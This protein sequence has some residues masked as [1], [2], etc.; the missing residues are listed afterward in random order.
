MTRPFIPDFKPQ[1]E[2]LRRVLG[3]LEADVMETMWQMGECSVRDV[4]ERMRLD[5]EL[6]YTTVMTVM[7]R[8]SDKGLLSRRQRGKAYIYVPSMGRE[9]YL[10][11]V[12]GEVMD[13]LLFSHRD[14]VISHFVD[15]LGEADEK[16]LSELE[17]IIRQKRRQ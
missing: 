9:Q 14:K 6:A 12:V 13:S 2:G 15:R 3:D 4:Y 10:D 5:K 17:E 16:A 7:S 1:R 11:K 8:L